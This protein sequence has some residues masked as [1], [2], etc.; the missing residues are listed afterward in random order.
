M[1]VL[2]RVALMIG[3]G[4]GTAF[5]RPDMAVATVDTET[6]MTVRYGDLNLATPAGQ[7]KLN[8]RIATATAAVCGEP[9]PLT[10]ERREMV[11]KCRAAA[12]Q[13]AWSA[14]AMRRS[15]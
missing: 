1:V 14:L 6:S 13:Q 11:D 3:V 9:G 15:N 10:S 5:L 2:N 7:S 4:I 8:R 12:K